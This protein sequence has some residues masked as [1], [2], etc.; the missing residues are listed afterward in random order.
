VQC[1]FV[2]MCLFIVFNMLCFFKGV[3]LLSRLLL[4][5]LFNFVLLID[6]FL[7]FF[8]VKKMF[9]YFFLML[10]SPF[11]KSF[12]FCICFQNLLFFKW[13]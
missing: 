3:C 4:L 1:L 9:S 2:C 13:G 8:K 10:L 12:I 11:S 5:L 6:F 7:H